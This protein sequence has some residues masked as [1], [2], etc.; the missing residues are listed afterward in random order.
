MGPNVWTII[1]TAL[2]ALIGYAVGSFTT[3]ATAKRQAQFALE[4]DRKKQIRL[5]EEEAARECE[6][7]LTSVARDRQDEFESHDPAESMDRQHRLAE[8][9]HKFL[10]TVIYLPEDLA[11]MLRRNMNIID[12]SDDIVRSGSHYHSIYSICANTL[13]D[14]RARVGAFLRDETYTPKGKLIDGYTLAYQE[15]LEER[16][17][18][19]E[20]HPDYEAQEKQRERAREAFYERHPELEE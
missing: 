12:Y 18:I 17:G 1:V 10:Q 6:A 7:I 20:G 19:M 3:F 13:I 11:K 2:A 5:R 16:E 14:T 4:N 8:N 9:A 15:Y